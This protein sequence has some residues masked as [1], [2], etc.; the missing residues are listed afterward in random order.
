MKMLG[1]W[2]QLFVLCSRAI[3]NIIMG[4]IF[5]MIAWPKVTARERVQE[6]EVSTSMWSAESKCRVS[7]RVYNYKDNK[8]YISSYDGSV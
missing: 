3:N 1:S 4:M 8:T 7:F 6:G 5:L 2:D